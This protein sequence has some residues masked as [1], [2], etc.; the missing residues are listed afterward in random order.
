ME[1]RKL[2]DGTSIST[3]GIGVGNYAYENVPG[4]EYFAIREE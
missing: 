4:E 1:Y 3:I 2:P